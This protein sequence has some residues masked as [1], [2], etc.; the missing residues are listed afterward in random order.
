MT[1]AW[2]VPE[3]QQV[4]DELLQATGAS[5]TT[6]RLVEP[7]SG[8]A[9]LAAESCQQGVVSMRTVVTPGI[10]A[11]PTYRYLLEEKKFLIQSD[12]SVDPIHPPRSLVQQLKVRAQ[13]L[14]PVLVSG[15]MVA[16]ISVHQQ[17]SPRQWSVADLAALADAVTQVE[18]WYHET[19]VPRDR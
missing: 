2:P 4:C 12:L 6:V 3:L 8:D 11:A 19:P 14:A 7:S 16:T 17:D 15:Q 13:M 5:R 10:V 18:A 9:S 1:Q